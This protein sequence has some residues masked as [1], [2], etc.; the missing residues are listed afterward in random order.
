MPERAMHGSRARQGFASAMQRDPGRKINQE[1]PSSFPVTGRDL[2]P[3]HQ[4]FQPARAECVHA[5]PRKI[6]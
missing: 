2:P 3:P 4:P 5:T 6:E 1:S